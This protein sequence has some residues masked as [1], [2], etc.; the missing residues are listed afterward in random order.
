M[1]VDFPYRLEWYR[2]VLQQT[3]VNLN[4][5]LQLIPHKCIGTVLV[6]NGM[7]RYYSIYH[8]MHRDSQEPRRRHRRRS[9]GQSR[10]ASTGTGSTAASSLAY[11]AD[12]N[13]SNGSDDTDSTAEVNDEVEAGRLTTDAH[14]FVDPPSYD[15]LIKKNIIDA[16]SPDYLLAYLPQWLDRLFG[17]N[18]QRYY[19][20][21]WPNMK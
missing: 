5:R 12:E 1:N 6:L 21:T 11:D 16:T 8:A 15:E 4:R 9:T 7:R 20:S 17:G 18:L 3:L 19:I 2:R 14:P 10:S 13:A